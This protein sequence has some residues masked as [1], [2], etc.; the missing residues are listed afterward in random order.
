VPTSV[1]ML[2]EEAPARELQAPKLEWYSWRRLPTA[3]IHILIVEFIHFYAAIFAWL[4]LINNINARVAM[5]GYYSNSTSLENYFSK[6][7]FFGS[8]DSITIHFGNV[9]DTYFLGHDEQIQYNVTTLVLPATDIAGANIPWLILAWTVPVGASLLMIYMLVNLWRRCIWSF[10]GA[11]YLDFT[12]HI[13]KT[14]TYRRLIALMSIGPICL[15]ILWIA[16]IWLFELEDQLSVLKAS[17]LSGIMLLWAMNRLAFPNT[18][19]HFWSKSQEFRALTFQRSL[20]HLL[21]SSNKSFGLKLVDALWR[22]EY[23]DLT[24]LKRYCPN[25]D[26]V[27]DV[28]RICQSAQRVEV[29][30]RETFRLNRV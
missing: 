3:T 14:P 6:L 9:S 19:V 11:A 5:S 23:G 27:A 17:T 24:G 25:P 12:W 7:F 8:T 28:F 1:F 13:S 21:L 20:L 22:A 10:E 16:Q 30:E 15:P 2:Q 26:T 29:E 4:R 18:P